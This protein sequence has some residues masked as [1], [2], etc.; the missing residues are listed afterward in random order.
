MNVQLEQYINNVDH[1]VLRH[2]I[3][4][5]HQTVLEVVLKDVSVLMD[6]YGMMAAVWMLPLVQVCELLIVEHF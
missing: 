4:L 1:F 5:E 6:K 2:A 3:I